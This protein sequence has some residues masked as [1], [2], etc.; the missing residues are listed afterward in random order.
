MPAENMNLFVWVTQPAW[1]CHGVVKVCLL[2]CI[3][4]YTCSFS[5][6]MYKYY[7]DNYS[8]IWLWWYLWLNIHLNIYNILYIFNISIITLQRYIYI[9]YV[10]IQIRM[11][12]Y[13]DAAGIFNDIWD[14]FGVSAGP[15]R[16]SLASVGPKRVAAKEKRWEA[17]NLQRSMAGWWFGC[18]FLAFSHEYW[19]CHPN[20]LSYFSEGWL[21][22]QPDG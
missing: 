7:I 21:N 13:P 19:E 14:M 17:R 15:G 10:Y 5:I 6:A 2:I 12:T 22:H 11:Y 1:M 18:H 9:L 16:W 8:H 20:W 4:M 3:Y